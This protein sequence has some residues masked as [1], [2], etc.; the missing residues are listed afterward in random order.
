MNF[1]TFFARLL[2]YAFQ[3]VQAAAPHFQQHETVA[4]VKDI[5]AGA[6]QA[7]A[8][9]HPEHAESA[10]AAASAV[11]AT[12]DAVHA[13]YHDARKPAAVAAAGGQ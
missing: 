1:L 8:D 7:A 5:I 6:A 4:A 12:L 3:I 10:N 9:T 13:I 11:V 2:P